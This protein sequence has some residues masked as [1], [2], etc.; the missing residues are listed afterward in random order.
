MPDPEPSFFIGSIPIMGELLLAPMDGIT[1][2]PYRAMIRRLGSAISTSEFINTLE[3]KYREK[4]VLRKLK[5][6]PFERPFSAQMLDND[7]IRMAEAARIIFDRLQP[8]IFDIN[9]GCPDSGVVGRGAGSALMKDPLKISQMI[10]LVVGAVPV[11]V[12]AKIRLGWANESQNYLDIAHIVQ[13]EGAKAIAIH[14]RTRKQGYTGTARWEPIAEVKQALHIPVI[15]NGD[16]HFVADISRL[17]VLTN[18]DGVMIGRAAISNPWI[19]SYRDREDV[20]PQE[21][22]NL[23]EQQL[24]EMIALDGLA[25]LRRFRKFVKAYLT[26]Y[27]VDKE[28]IHALL[29]CN[30]PEIFLS[31]VND[32][33]TRI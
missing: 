5:F 21:V 13:E 22:R 18:C 29:T 25:G 6:E 10:R 19:F 3:I 4:M 27:Q 8:D 17:K 23:M 1:D 16:V 32:L 15:G 11:P 31:M 33:F 12:T 20:S 24:K 26:P 7:P 2:A 9:L 28:V 30:D 14:G